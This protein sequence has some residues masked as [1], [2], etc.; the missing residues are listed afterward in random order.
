[1]CEPDGFKHARYSWPGPPDKILYPRASISI[2]GHAGGCEGGTGGGGGTGGTGS[3]GGSAGG[4]GQV[5]TSPG[6]HLVILSSLC[7]AQR[8]YPISVV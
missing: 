4:V 3:K 7:F 2:G 6:A 5:K 1:M 8:L